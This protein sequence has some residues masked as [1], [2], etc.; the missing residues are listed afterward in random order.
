MY[1]ILTQCFP[2][3]VGGIENL[4]RDLANSISG[5]GEELVVLADGKRC[6]D[7]KSR[8]YKVR[9]YHGW[10][11]LRRWRKGRA[12][13]SA[14]N[15]PDLKLVIADS[16]KSL[17][18]L[19][20]ASAPILCLAH[21]MEF[22]PEPSEKRQAR[23]KAALAKADYVFANSH[24][25]ADLARPYVDEEKLKVVTL[26]VMPQPEARRDQ[27]AAMSNTCGAKPMIAT[28][29]RL[30]MRKGIDM[31]IEAMASL[32]GQASLLIAGSGPDTDRLKELA[33]ASPF[34][35][36][37]HFLGR[38][39]DEER[40]ALF[41]IADVFAMPT[42]REGASVEGFGLVYLEAAWYGTPSLAGREG[43]ASDA[44]LDGKTGLLCDGADQESVEDALKRLINDKTLRHSLGEAAAQHARS[45]LWSDKLALYLDP[46]K[47]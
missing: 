9:R 19:E 35:E 1:L 15:H 18:H 12:A 33:E 16:W 31:L 2:P 38:I 41:S 6:A 29:C 45:Q 21:G 23:M 3:N 13:A 44:V 39:S 37:I 8:G 24:F 10:K 34:A 22:P 46:S 25:T 30:E 40:A 26:P 14:G 42:R 36:D 32:R 11:P 4:M 43:G 47:A 27:M 7:D 17:E 5:A 28:L 20:G